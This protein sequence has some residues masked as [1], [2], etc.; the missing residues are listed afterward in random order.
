MGCLA[1]THISHFRRRFGGV[2]V[3]AVARKKE[4]PLVAGLSGRLLACLWRSVVALLLVVIRCGLRRAACCRESKRYA[5]RFRRTSDRR[6]PAARGP[7]DG[8]YEFG[9][10]VTSAEKGLL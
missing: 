7:A 4:T 9:Q 5:R 8:K 6:F 3:R 1:A 10:Y 2:E